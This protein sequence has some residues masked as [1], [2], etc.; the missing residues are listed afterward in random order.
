MAKSK[1]AAAVPT[2]TPE[3]AS[4]LFRLVSLLGRAAQ[5]RAA[6]IRALR[7]NV[8][9]FYRDLEILR[10]A[11]IS[12]SLKKNQYVLDD[13]AAKA[14]VRLP[15]PDPGLTLGEARLLSR[16]RSLAHRKLRDQLRRIEK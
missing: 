11:G 2:I 5:S 9:A 4:R 8:R 7:F 13:T 15:F 14:L 6:L 1:P 3:R 16:G 10:D 12:V